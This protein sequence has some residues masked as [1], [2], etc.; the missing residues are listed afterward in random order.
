M[1]YKYDFVSLGD[2]ADCDTNVDL[3]DNDEILENAWKWLED[4]EEGYSNCPFCA[5]KLESIY[6]QVPLRKKFIDPFGHRLEYW[7]NFWICRN[8][9][10]WMFKSFTY[11]PDSLLSDYYYNLAISKIQEFDNNLPVEFTSELAQILRRN[12]NYWHRLN[13]NALEVYIRDI[14]KANYSNC[15]VIHVGKPGDRGVDVLF[16]DTQEKR[17]LIQVKRR[18]RSDATEGFGTLQN[19][20]GAMVMNDS[21]NG[22]L[23]ST[24]DHFSYKVF[25]EAKTLKNRGFVVDL[26]DK[27]KLN[28]MLD[29]VLPTKP[30]QGF[31][32]EWE[33]H[34]KRLWRNC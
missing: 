14:F 29:A 19:L 7:G 5:Y 17:W 6:K 26:V 1:Y 28:R 2:G 3:P 34:H 24:V 18:S 21:L 20:L 25:E 33:I 16:I 12:P 11:V 23:V 30:W 32:D 15:E 4:H 22:I 10:F 13:P 8:C 31:I 9:M 27:G